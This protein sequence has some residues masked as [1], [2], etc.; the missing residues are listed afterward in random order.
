MLAEI[1]ADHVAV[2]LSFP[3]SKKYLILGNDVK[4]VGLKLMNLSE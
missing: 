3:I 4:S 2:V 1:E